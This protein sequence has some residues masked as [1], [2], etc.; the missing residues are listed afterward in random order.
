MNFK[1]KATKAIISMCASVIV[2]MGILALL[3]MLLE[4]EIK[5]YFNNWPQDAQDLAV[6]EM[7]RYMISHYCRPQ[8]EV[9]GQTVLGEN[10]YLFWDENETCKSAHQFS[11]WKITE[12]KVVA[13][14]RC[15]L[16]DRWGDYAVTI[17]RDPDQINGQSWC[18]YRYFPKAEDTGAMDN[19]RLPPYWDGP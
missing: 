14:F 10:K 17:F 12:S 6:S 18:D 13:F 4:Y 1:Q 5:H 19:L 2:A 15:D 9:R 8:M 7:S 11:G 16:E 3:E